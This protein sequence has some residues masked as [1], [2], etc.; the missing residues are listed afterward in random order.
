MPL[1]TAFCN[2]PFMLFNVMLWRFAMLVH[3]AVC[4]HFNSVE[5]SIM[6]LHHKL[7]IHSSVDGHSEA[8][9]SFCHYKQY[10]S[11]HFMPHSCALA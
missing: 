9:A 4:G 10:F 11:E 5:H 3:R 8:V 6:L 2:L 7:F 1:G